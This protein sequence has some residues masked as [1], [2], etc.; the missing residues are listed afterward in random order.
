ML[1]FDATATAYDLHPL[2]DPVLGFGEKLLG[3]EPRRRGAVAISVDVVE[4]IR[5]GAMKL[6]LDD[7]D[8]EYYEPEE[9]DSS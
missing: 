6:F 5:L 1:Q 7:L 8:A 4:S 3:R 9:S 2:G